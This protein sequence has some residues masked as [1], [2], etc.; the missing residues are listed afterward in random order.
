MRPF[1]ILTAGLAV[2]LT[3]LL[4]A[5][6]RQNAVLWTTCSFLV[7]SM[8]LQVL[9]EGSHWQLWPLYGASALLLAGVV[10]RVERFKGLPLYVMGM[11]A[12]LLIGIAVGSSLVFPM[13]QLPTPTGEYAV[14]TRIVYTTDQ[15]R[16]EGAGPS[17]TGKRELMIQ[18]WYPAQKP[19]RGSFFWPVRHAF[20]QRA[21]EVTARGSYRAVLETNSFQDA[22]VLQSDPLPVVLY[23]PGWQGERTEG[24]FQAEEL[25][26]HGFVVVAVDHTFFGG[27]VAFPD[28]RVVDSRNA[29]DLGNFEHVSLDQEAALGAHYVQIE[30]LDDIFVL[31]QLEVMNADPASPFFRRLDMA[32]VGS[33]GFSIGGAV[34]EQVAFA[35]SRVR[36]AVNLDGWSFGDL[37]KRGLAKPLMIIYESRANTLPTTEQLH[38]GPKSQQL[39]WQYSAQD[40]ERVAAS[41]RQFGG[42]VLFM[43]GTNH[44]DFTDR[45]LFSTLRRLSGRGSL[46]PSRAHSIVN[47]YTLAFFSQTLKAIDEPLLDGS[48]SPFKEVEYHRFVPEARQH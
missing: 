38:A 47:A 16:I 24:T 28:G 15:S 30:T 1:E 12:L 37:Q 44:V 11:L 27:R 19:S 7:A 34:S 4:L 35:D 9:R 36:C 3:F 6:K 39:Y 32:R 23:N 46:L 25:A 18:I 26:S 42:W 31:D 33:L 21:S 14:G 45:S 10:L 41:M 29:P 22:A 17:P 48:S 8:I 40:Y 2:V 5:T 20:Y 13:F 43:E